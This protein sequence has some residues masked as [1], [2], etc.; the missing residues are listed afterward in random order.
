MSSF[1]CT[2]AE[3]VYAEFAGP[4]YVVRDRATF[5]DAAPKSSEYF[6]VM[7]SRRGWEYWDFRNR[8]KVEPLAWRRAKR[9]AG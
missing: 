3:Q 6:G 1:D 2:L 4:R 8:H 7:T 5:G 9:K